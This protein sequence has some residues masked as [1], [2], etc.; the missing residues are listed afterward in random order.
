[1]L[2]VD[3]MKGLC[4]KGCSRYRGQQEVRARWESASPPKPSGYHFMASEKTNAHVPQRGVPSPP[5]PHAGSLPVSLTFGSSHHTAELRT[6]VEV[7]SW[8]GRSKVEGP[9]GDRT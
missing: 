1:M 9:G 4:G 6:G 7:P 2:Y 3:Q 5:N 8:E